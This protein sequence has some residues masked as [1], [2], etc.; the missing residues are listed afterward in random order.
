MNRIELRKI[1]NEEIRNILNEDM[2]LGL[3][4]NGKI[5]KVIV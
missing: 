2:G 3:I 1:I 5:K 4:V